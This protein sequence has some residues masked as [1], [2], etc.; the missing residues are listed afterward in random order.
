MF[1]PTVSHSLLN[2]VRAA[3]SRTGARTYA[4]GPSKAAESNIPLYLSL[5]GVAGLGATYAL[6]GFSPAAAKDAKAQ[7]K[8]EGVA[9]VLQGAQGALSKDQ[10]KDFK[11]KEI[12]PYNHDSST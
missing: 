5:A 6:G 1:R 2:S 11:I 7:G 10:F 8:E 12:R 3:S 4:S 9:A